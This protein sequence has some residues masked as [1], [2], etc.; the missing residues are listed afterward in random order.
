MLERI[1]GISSEQ[2]WYVG[3]VS[4]DIP[5]KSSR[6]R[7]DVVTATDPISTIQRRG[8][9]HAIGFAK[10]GHKM[11]ASSGNNW[12]CVHHDM[13]SSKIIEKLKM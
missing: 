5:H 2:F 12:L 10:V 9:R 4:P 6:L 7:S 3:V 11:P 1:I 13:F 8:P